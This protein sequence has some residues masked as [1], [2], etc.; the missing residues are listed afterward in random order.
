MLWATC[1][2]Y[3]GEKPEEIFWENVKRWAYLEDTIAQANKAE[4]LQFN[5]KDKDY[6]NGKQIYKCNKCGWFGNKELWQELIR[7]HKALKVA[8]DA[9]KGI[10]WCAQDYAKAQEALKKITALEQKDVK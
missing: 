1:L 2:W 5:K 3:G 9:L 6:T 4:R 8:V 7:T 10:D